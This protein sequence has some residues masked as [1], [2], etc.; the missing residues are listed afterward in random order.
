M[1][2]SEGK[3]MMCKCGK[4]AAGGIFGKESF[5]VWCS[6]CDP[7]KNYKTEILDEKVILDDS[8]VINLRET[9]K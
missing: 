3:P 2:D 1:D 4:K 6:E 9:S 8:W 5:Q 7:S